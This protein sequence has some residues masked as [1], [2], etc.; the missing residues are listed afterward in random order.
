MKKH[1]LE[2]TRA[3]RR[4]RRKAVLKRMEM[5][6]AKLAKSADKRGDPEADD[7]VQPDLEDEW[8]RLDTERRQIEK[9]GV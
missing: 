1:P 6:E 5:I 8:G 4:T 9:I 7:G 3:Q 2:M